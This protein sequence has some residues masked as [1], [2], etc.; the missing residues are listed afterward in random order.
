MFVCKRDRKG[1]LLLPPFSLLRLEFCG[2]D[3]FH[4]STF[5][6]ESSVSTHVCSQ[7][8]SQ[9][10]SK[11]KFWLPPWEKIKAISCNE[12]AR[13][14]DTRRNLADSTCSWSPSLLASWK[15]W[16]H[17]FSRNIPEI[18]GKKMFT[19][20]ISERHAWCHYWSFWTE[21]KV[22]GDTMRRSRGQSHY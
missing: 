18:L 4:F 6:V 22:H 14:N 16:K 8:L 11:A 5:L 12:A 15:G 17:T 20:D 3:R 2:L 9:C 10:C 19:S 1:G 7:G 21:M 13:T